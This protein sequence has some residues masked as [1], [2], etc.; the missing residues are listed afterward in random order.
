M[1]DGEVAVTVRDSG[2][3][4]AVVP[5]GAQIRRVLS[6]VAL[7]RTVPLHP[8]LDEALAATRPAADSSS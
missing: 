3:W 6:V 5:G 7:D 1:R 8:T 2:R 4:S